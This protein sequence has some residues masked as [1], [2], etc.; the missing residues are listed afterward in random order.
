MKT[1]KEVLLNEATSKITI[2]NVIKSFLKDMKTVS[3]TTW[4]MT[5]PT[6]DIAF[7]GGGVYVNNSTNK[8][9]TV[10]KIGDINFYTR[11][12]DEGVEMINADTGRLL[13]T[14]SIKKLCTLISKPVFEIAGK[15]VTTFERFEK[16]RNGNLLFHFKNGSVLSAFTGD[17]N[18]VTTKTNIQ[19]AL[20]TLADVGIKISSKTIKEIED[21]FPDSFM[22]EK[23]V[24]KDADELDRFISTFLPK[25]KVDTSGIT[26]DHIS[27][28]RKV[29]GK[30]IHFSTNAGSSYYGKWTKFDFDIKTPITPDELR[31]EIKR[32][33][34]YYEEVT[35]QQTNYAK[36]FADYIR[37]GNGHRGNPVY[38]D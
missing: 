20:T 1:F 4:H 9:G 10:Y 3:V 29:N 25:G 33:V 12:D 21:A 15:A 16:T 13:D 11:I 6:L 14:I 23:K 26:G 18:A 27:F 7:Y 2:E 19:H 36:G 37:K 28:D 22:K 8:K 5:V 31:S 17:K 38:M 24:F 30:S 35:K 32:Y 34:E